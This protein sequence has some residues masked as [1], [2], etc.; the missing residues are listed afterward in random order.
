MFT[1]MSS[2]GQRLGQVL[3]Q[4]R[5]RCL[6]GRIGNQPL[7]LSLRRVSRDVDDASEL[8]QA[9]KRKRMTNTSDRTESSDVERGHPLV[10]VKILEAGNTHI[11]RSS[12]IDQARR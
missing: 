12:G 2:V 6:R 11:D 7:A 1:R 9:Q 8:S 5:E 4:A 10:V 3:C